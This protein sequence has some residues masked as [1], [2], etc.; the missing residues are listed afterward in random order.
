MQYDKSSTTS[1][2][3]IFRNTVVNIKEKKAKRVENGCLYRT[4]NGSQMGLS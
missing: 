1:K 4:E 2:S 3:I